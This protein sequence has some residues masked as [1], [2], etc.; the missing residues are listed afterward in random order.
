MNSDLND[1]DQLEC[2]FSMFQRFNGGHPLKQKII[3]DIREHFD[4]KWSKDRNQA[5]DEE[6]EIKI[7]MQLPV[8]V[9]DQLY[10]GFLFSD[11]LSNFSQFFRI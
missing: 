1:G 8:D 7:L 10:S 3:E 4:Y 11:F 9:Q 2:F 5:I 6:E